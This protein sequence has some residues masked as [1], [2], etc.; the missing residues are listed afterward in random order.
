MPDLTL[1][2]KR[3]YFNLIKDGLKPFEFRLFN[4]Y[5]IKRLDDK[6][7]NCIWI[8]DG[9]PSK[10][11]TSRWLKFPYTGFDIKTIY[12]QEWIDKIDGP[13]KV[14][15]IKLNPIA[16]YIPFRKKIDTEMLLREW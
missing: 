11:D 14:F 3:K 13:V 4:L 2:V 1:H 15:A 6:E 10:L 16:D 5:W 9:Y 7:Y 8:A 12:H